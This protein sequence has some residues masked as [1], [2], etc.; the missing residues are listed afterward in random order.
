MRKALLVLTA[1]TLLFAGMLFLPINHAYAACVK[2]GCNGLDPQ[3]TGC[4]ASTSI[5]R[6]QLISGPEDPNHQGTPNGTVY[7]MWSNTCSTNWTRVV[8]NGSLGVSW[9]S[10]HAELWLLSFNSSGYSVGTRSSL[11]LTHDGPDYCG[12]SSSLSCGN[13][14]TF[15]G[16]MYYAPTAEVESVGWAMDSDGS[17]SIGCPYTGA[18]WR[19]SA[20]GQT[21]QCWGS[22][23]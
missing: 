16:N 5:V 3:A 12:S 13:A 18:S 22:G 7:T 21:P 14:Q 15:Y 11:S 17:T 8:M 4:T 2:T 9:F 19:Y 20:P 1:I 10:I 23:L 6:S